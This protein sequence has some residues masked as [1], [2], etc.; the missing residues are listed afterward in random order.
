MTVNIF[1]DEETW[2]DKQKD[3]DDNDDNDGNDDNDDNDDNNDNEDN[4]DNDTETTPWKS[5]PRDLWILRHIFDTLPQV[6]DRGTH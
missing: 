1:S 6:S 4:E 3:I 2:Y 5:D